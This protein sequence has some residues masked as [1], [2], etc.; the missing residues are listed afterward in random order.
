MIG[1]GFA[2]PLWLCVLFLALAGA[3]DMLSGLYRGIIW[4]ESVPNAMRGRLSGIE[5]ISYMTGPLLGN[6]R[7]GLLAAK[8]SVNFSLIS[9]GVVCFI[10]V[11]ITAVLL[12]RF[13]LYKGQKCSA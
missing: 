3:A 10:A 12:P 7:A 13:W 2:K 5:M 9:G 6:G 11:V 1:V 4:N 8:Y